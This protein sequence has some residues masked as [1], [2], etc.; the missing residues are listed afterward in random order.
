MKETNVIVMA[1]FLGSGKTTLLQK[2]L[3]YLQDNHQSYAVVMNEIGDTSIDTTLIG[4][5]TPV[6]EI[7]NGCICCSSKEQFDQAIMSTI[8]QYHPDYLFVECSGVS[9][10]YEV[11]DSCLNPL[12]SHFVNFKGVITTL[13]VPRWLYLQ[14]ND[15]SLFRL[16]YE[17]L[18]YANVVIPTKTDL[19]DPEALLSFNDQ[20]DAL[21]LTREQWIWNPQATT[22]FNQLDKGQPAAKQ[23]K[24]E[25]T[26]Q[27]MHIHTVRYTFKHPISQTAFEDWLRQLDDTILRVKGFL[28]FDHHPDKCY[29]F[30]YAFGV[31]LYEEY[32]MNPQHNL[33]V[34]GT[35]FD[36]EAIYKQ[37]EQLDSQQD[38]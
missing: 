13:D 30:Q 27:H 11:I 25:M 20:R 3:C 26:T 4:K 8:Q 36:T 17:Q 6:N 32:D 19:L 15:P 21:P 23:K 24:D 22:I 7:L 38:A 2:L 14:E 9:H 12:M 34:I 1:G 28:S 5:D 31:P 29:L 37:L 33:V 18:A 16:M 10:P 35:D